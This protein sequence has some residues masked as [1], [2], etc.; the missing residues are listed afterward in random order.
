MSEAIPNTPS[1]EPA[2]SDMDLLARVEA[3]VRT[4]GLVLRERFTTVSPC[5]KRDTVEE[6]MAVLEANDKAVLDVLRP[7]LN[8]L[9]PGARWVEDEFE[10]GA[11]PEGEWWIVD[12]AEGNI[13]HVHAMPEWAITAT[14]VRDNAAVFSVVHLP[15]A[16][17]TYTALAGGGAFL[18]GRALHV[19]GKTDL[20]L[21]VAATS[22][23][24]PGLAEA[25][26]ERIGSSITRMLLET[27]VVRVSVAGTLHLL[28]VAAGRM[29]VFWQY[30]GT[31]AD[32]LPGALLVT[33]AGG[34][35]TDAEG[36]PWTPGSE[37]LLAAAVP[38]LHAQAVAALAR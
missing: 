16:G 30:A 27:L 8:R 11:L 2:R 29:D 34:C 26:L 1:T 36:R 38:A 4:A 37:S 35:V 6:L 28:N 31:R 5:A 24:R 3:D 13:N 14:L 17:E 7:R 15:L 18:D 32:L 23:A 25:T 21:A 10:G 33:E 12:P 20:R 9:R 19:S 22:Q